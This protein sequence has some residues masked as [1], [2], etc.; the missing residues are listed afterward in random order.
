MES[1]LDGLPEHAVLLTGSPENPVIENHSG[2]AVIGYVLRPRN[3]MLLAFS[4][5]PAG[6]PDG[7]SLYA[8]GAIPVNQPGPMQEPAFQT[9]S[10]STRNGNVADVS[11]GKGP[12]VIATTLR[13]VVFRRSICRGG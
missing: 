3:H 5:Q 2:R 1:H 13:C 6:I 12:I 11:P 8:I 4:A 10:L 7:G 9:T